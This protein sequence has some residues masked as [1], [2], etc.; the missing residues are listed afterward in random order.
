MYFKTSKMKQKFVLFLVKYF[1]K[2][3]KLSSDLKYHEFRKNYKISPSFKFNGKNI[4]F[5]GEGEIICGSQS[6]IGEYSTIQSINGQSVIIGKGCMIS[7]NVRMYTSSPITDQD[8]SVKPLIEKKGDIK[9]G[10]YVWIGANVFINPGVIIGDNSI[11]GAN[12][13][14]TKNIPE[15]SIYGGVPAKLIRFKKGNGN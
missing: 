6:Y 7:H 11:I 1:D 13:V 8:F 15:G 10:N 2:L 3:Y 5:Y 4:L 12:S 14:V 9:I